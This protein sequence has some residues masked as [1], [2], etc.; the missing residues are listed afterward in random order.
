MPL[1]PSCAKPQGLIRL[2]SATVALVVASGCTY[3]SEQIGVDQ[4]GLSEVPVVREVPEIAALVPAEVAA[5]G[6]LT[7][8]AELTYAPME[9]VGADGRSAVGMDIDIAS[10]VAEVLGLE[11]QVMSSSFDSIIPALGSRYELG[12][13]AFT[14]T[15]ARLEAVNMVAYLEAGSQLAVQAGNPDGV[16]PDYL[17]G[18]QIAVQ[19]GTVQQEELEA[20][21]SS[22]CS[23]NPVAIF[24]FESQADATANLVGG[25]VAAMYADSPIIGYAVAQTDGA[26]VE[27]GPIRDA[28]PY[29][30]AIAKDDVALAEAVYAAV[31]HLID[32]GTMAQIA[33][34]WGNSQMLIEQARL[35]R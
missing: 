31:Q 11:P 24:P 27:L 30:L 6:I 5:D 1:T 25:R 22:D 23:D 16:D 19:I 34:H 18:T 26:L 9:F 13:S 3:A 35:Y 7:I 8:A 32:T 20:L 10:A 29:G 17:C 4:P 14:I 33:E 21:N 15:P 12:A 2:V 28:A